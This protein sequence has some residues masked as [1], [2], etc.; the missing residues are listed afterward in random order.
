MSCNCRRPRRSATRPTSALG[1]RHNDRSRPAAAGAGARAQQRRQRVGTPSNSTQLNGPSDLSLSILLPNADAK[2][3]RAMMLVTAEQVLL[4]EPKLALL[5]FQPDAAARAVTSGSTP[6]PS[7][8]RLFPSACLPRRRRRRCRWGPSSRTT[9]ADPAAQV[10]SVQTQASM[11]GTA[12]TGSEKVCS[13]NR[14]LVVL[15]HAP[16]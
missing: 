6:T 5:L 4:E 3:T 1:C 7:S 2:S 14:T 15:A 13:R 16:Q 12:S 9:P 11:H 8:R 10:L